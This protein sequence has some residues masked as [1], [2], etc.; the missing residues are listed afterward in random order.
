MLIDDEQ[1]LEL[2]TPPPNWCSVCARPASW[3]AVVSTRWARLCSGLDLERK[4]I[5]LTFCLVDD[6]PSILYK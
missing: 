4:K 6:Q 1:L 2:Y 3:Q 5:C